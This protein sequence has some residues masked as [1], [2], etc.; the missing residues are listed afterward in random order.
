M[1]APLT[2]FMALGSCSGLNRLGP[3]VFTGELAKCTALPSCRGE[4][5]VLEKAAAD[6]RVLYAEPRLRASTASC[7]LA[8]LPCAS[9]CVCAA[10]GLNTKEASRTSQLGQS[11]TDHS[12]SSALRGDSSSGGAGASAGSTSKQQTSACSATVTDDVEVR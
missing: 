4:C 2:A 10:M 12:G 11:L 8:R 6:A 5:M 3:S 1:Y 7:R 9:L